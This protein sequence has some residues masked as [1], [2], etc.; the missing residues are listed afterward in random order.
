MSLGVLLVTGVRYS[1]SRSA[2]PACLA[3]TSW[4]TVIICGSLPILIICPSCPTLINGKLSAYYVPY[5]L[6]CRF[7]VSSHATVNCVISC[8]FIVLLS[9]V[10]S[11]PSHPVCQLES[12]ISCQSVSFGLCLLSSLSISFPQSLQSFSKR[13]RFCPLMPPSIY[14]S[15][16]IHLP[17]LLPVCPLDDSF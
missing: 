10:N 11:S 6:W 8:H 7:C 3:V 5:L 12:A 1:A 2:I 13:A 14:S 15:L 17:V 4:H 9:I 16:S